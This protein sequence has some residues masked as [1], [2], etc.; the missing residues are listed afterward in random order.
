MLDPFLG[1]GTTAAVAKRLGRCFIGIER[2]EAYAEAARGA[3]RRGDAAP[4]RAPSRLFA[5][6]GPRRGFPS[7]LWS[8]SG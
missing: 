2:E 7:A 1:S 4:I 3:A 5:A 8:R 6:S